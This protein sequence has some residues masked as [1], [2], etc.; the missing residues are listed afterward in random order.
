MKSRRPRRPGRPR[1]YGR[2]Q[3][4]VHLKATAPRSVNRRQL[5][6]DFWAKPPPPSPEHQVDLEDYIA[7]LGEKP[8]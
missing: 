3:F 4:K 8:K 1:G 2:D 7:S 6:M 5:A